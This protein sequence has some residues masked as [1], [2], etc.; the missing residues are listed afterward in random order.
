[1]IFVFPIPLFTIDVVAPET[2]VL[3]CNN[4]PDAVTVAI[5]PLIVTSR[6]VPKST[7]LADPTGVVLSLILIPSPGCAGRLISAEPSIAG[8]APVSCPDGMFVSPEPDPENEDAVIIPDVFIL[9]VPDTALDIPA[10]VAYATE[11]VET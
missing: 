8:S 2:V 6:P 5:P 3:D 11:A 4:P 10:V 9:I 7:V 1:M